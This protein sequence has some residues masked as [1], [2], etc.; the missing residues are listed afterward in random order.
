M[1]SLVD[2]F[3]GEKHSFFKGKYKIEKH[4]VYFKIYE[5]LK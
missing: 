2:S 3:F 1:K 4:F 5:V